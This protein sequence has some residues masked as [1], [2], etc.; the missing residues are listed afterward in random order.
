MDQFTPKQVARAIGVS[1]ASLKRWCD[2]GKIAFVRTVGGHRRIEIAAVLDFLKSTGR[3]MVR[4]E[5]LRLP[6]TC[7][8]GKTVAKRAVQQTFDALASGDEQRLE[9]VLIDLQLAGRSLPEMIDDVIAPALCQ[10]GEHW[11]Q[12]KLEIFCERRACDILC[13]SV[14]ALM[15]RLPLPRPDA[16]R[17]LGC[18]APTDPYMLP[19]LFAEATLREAGWHAESL[20]NWLPVSTLRVAIE[21][22][23]PRLFWL[24]ASWVANHERFLGEAQ[25]IFDCAVRNGASMVVGGRFLTNPVRARLRYAA[26]C[27]TFGHLLNFA[28]SLVPV[29]QRPTDPR[30]PPANEQP[31][32]TTPA[33]ARDRTG[34]PAAPPGRAAP[35]D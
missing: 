6:A 9:H 12:N 10:I 13:R 2:G 35:G 22:A 28:A 25:V 5:I 18:A 19:T 1:D 21:R 26:F 20:G 23:Q 8:S 7:G 16:P 3:P 24:S 31:N 15:R 14:T 32:A 27:D 29:P 4:P 34:S 11:Q 17:A 33:V 30:R